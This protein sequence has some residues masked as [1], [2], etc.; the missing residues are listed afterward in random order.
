MPLHN[1]R[2]GIGTNRTNQMMK[3][4][5]AGTSLE[6]SSKKLTNNSARK[7]LVNKIKNATLNGPP[8]L[9]HNSRTGILRHTHTFTYFV[10]KKYIFSFLFLEFISLI[11]R[12]APIKLYRQQYTGS[13]I[14]QRGT[15]FISELIHINY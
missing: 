7:T 5:V 2:T 11:I 15:L 14:V 9:L 10:A 3:R 13:V 6:S 1:P 8:L 4:I 12:M